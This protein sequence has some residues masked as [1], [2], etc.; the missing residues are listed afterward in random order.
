MLHIRALEVDYARLVDI[1]LL[2]GVFMVEVA[3]GVELMVGCV[4]RLDFGV[5]MGEDIFCVALV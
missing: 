4:L 3:E 2:G 5:Q 1:L